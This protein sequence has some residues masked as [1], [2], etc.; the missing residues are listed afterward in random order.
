[1]EDLMSRLAEGEISDA[2]AE[3]GMRALV[4]SL[5]MGGLAV[6]SGGVDK[7]TKRDLARIGPVLREEYR[8][9]RRRITTFTL[10]QEYL[11]N[12]GDPE[13]YERKYKL[14]KVT[15]AQLVATVPGYAQRALT[16]YE[17]AKREKAPAALT[18][19]RWE[20]NAGESCPGC[21]EQHARGVQPRA[22]FPPHGSQ[23]CEHHCKCELVLVEGEAA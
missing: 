14:P 4:K 13:E 6:G 15:P 12:G 7:V 20:L 5:H 18:H 10:Y 2:E 16:T 23:E 8:F 9:L 3:I 22:S 17:N 21:T 1:M 19:A 11:A